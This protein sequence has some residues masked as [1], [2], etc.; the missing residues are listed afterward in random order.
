M[1]E[2]S[3]DIF[4]STLKDDIDATNINQEVVDFS[5]YVVR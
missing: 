1:S 4:I 5:S 2:T 3:A